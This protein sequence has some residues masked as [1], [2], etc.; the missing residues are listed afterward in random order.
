MKALPELYKVLT[1]LQIAEI[2][3]RQDVE[4]MNLQIGYMKYY[5]TSSFDRTLNMLVQLFHSE[6]N[7]ALVVR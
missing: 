4:W 2:L 1:I 7:L 6:T 5:F 3:Q